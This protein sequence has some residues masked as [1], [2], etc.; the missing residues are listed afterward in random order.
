VKQLFRVVPMAAALLMGCAAPTS[1]RPSVDSSLAPDQIV[2]ALSNRKL[3]SRGTSNDGFGLATFKAFLQPL[4]TRCQADGGHLAA[5]APT[6]VRFTLRDANSAFH[7]ARVSMPL[8]L[9][10]RNGAGTL[11]SVEARYNETTFFPS[12]WAD[13]VF[14]YATIPLTFEPGAVNGAAR[15]SEA[16]SCQSMREQYTRRLRD[17]PKVGMKVQFGVIIDVRFPLVQVQYD[18]FGRRLKGREQEWVQ[19]YTLNAGTNCPQ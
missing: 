13:A 12:S 17:D 3:T 6:E 18:E 4:D 7:E 8:R 11:W 19:A 1:P 16:D 15:V 5:T 2:R 10:C 14:Y 9:A